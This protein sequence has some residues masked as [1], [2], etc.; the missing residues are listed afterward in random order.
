MDCL[1]IFHFLSPEERRDRAGI[2]SV[3]VFLLAL[4]AERIKMK[5]KHDCIRNI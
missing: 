2:S 3:F 5:I 4:A 1:H